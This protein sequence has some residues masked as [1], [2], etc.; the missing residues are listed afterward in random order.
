MFYEKDHQD[1]EHL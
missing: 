1:M